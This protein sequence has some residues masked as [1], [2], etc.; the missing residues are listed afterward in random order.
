[1]TD[2]PESPVA[3]ALQ[4]LTELFGAELREVR[5][6][7]VDGPTLAAA[8]NAVHASAAEL[9]RAEAVVEAA[10]LALAEKQDALLLK[11]QR[12]LAYARIYAEESPALLAR[13]EGLQLPR[14][15]KPVR[16]EAPAASSAPTAVAEPVAPRRRGRPPKSATAGASASDGSL[17]QEGAAGRP[18]LTVDADGLAAPSDVAA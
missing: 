15:R 4:S 5:F 14:G 11:G 7:D 10:R 3:P 18:E 17:F 13:L 9:A 16:P 1:M 2:L 8:V 6:P 12:A